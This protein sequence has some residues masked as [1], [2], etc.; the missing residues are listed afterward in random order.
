MFQDDSQ[1]RDIA[2]EDEQ[3]CDDAET[4]QAH[5]LSALR[6]L[7]IDTQVDDLPAVQSLFEELAHCRETVAS[8]AQ[9]MPPAAQLSGLAERL[10]GFLEQ[11]ER[12]VRGGIIDLEIAGPTAATAICSGLGVLPDMLDAG[13]LSKDAGK[14]LGKTVVQL[15]RALIKAVVATPGDADRQRTEDV[16][17]MLTWLSRGLKARLLASDD[18]P[19][20]DAFSY[21]LELMLTWA[22]ASGPS[23]LD[24]YRLA[25]C[26]VLI[27][28]I[29]QFGLLHLDGSGPSAT[30]N[31][32][33]LQAVLHGLCTDLPDIVANT[34]AVNGVQTA[35]VGNTIKDFADAGLL[36]QQ[37]Y[38]WLMP[39]IAILLQRMPR[40]P[41]REMMQ[42]GGQVL[43]NCS[44]FLRMLSESGLQQEDAFSACSSAY[45]TSCAH[46]T[47]M[48]NEEGFVLQGRVGQSLANLMSFV[49]AMARQEERHKPAGA[50]QAAEAKARQARL[51]VAA[52]R[53]MRLLGAEDLQRLSPRSI[54]GLL[55]ALSYIW[56][57]GLAPAGMCRALRQGL[58]AAIP[59][60][61]GRQWETATVALSLRA[62]VQLHDL[63]QG[64]QAQMQPG[65]L[66][67]LQLL[68][69]KPLA[70][71][72]QRLYCLQ[73]LRLGLQQKWTTPE[74]AALQGALRSLLRWDARHS[75]GMAELEA[76]IA[77]LRRR[78]EAAPARLEVPE[79]E[80]SGPAP[81]Q[82]GTA[83]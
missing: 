67:L 13:L 10:H 57:R 39:V 65:F 51:N 34:V 8:A 19:I 49:K 72:V 4:R 68:A 20:R 33:R 44:N 22:A 66:R 80:A 83:A 37:T 82:A 62:I 36:P 52:Q 29:R 77:S 28:T 26:F 2:D 11:F 60:S 27:N 5:T 40:V 56:G 31:R 9:R 17:A 71:E 21:A 74:Q 3:A 16:Q 43:A 35:N 69:R 70:D 75:P 50:Q 7:I 38:D 59:S 63:R 45:K 42:K 1:H 47:G 25:T 41:Q 79:A 32:Q 24:G 12:H 14:E 53:L 58:I 78:E 18:R 73:A 54:S 76:A 48:M 81:L 46:L 30:A 61:A 15:T 23:G 64:A 55:S 6:Q